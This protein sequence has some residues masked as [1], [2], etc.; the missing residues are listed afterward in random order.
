MKRKCRGCNRGKSAE[1]CWNPKKSWESGYNDGE[2][3]SSY[4]N[5]LFDRVFGVSSLEGRAFDV[6]LNYIE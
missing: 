5:D 2:E 6:A 1:E 4:G 3:E